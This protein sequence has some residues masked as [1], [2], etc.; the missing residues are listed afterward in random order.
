MIHVDYTWDLYPNKI[1]LDDELN[2]DRLGWQ[3]GDHFKLVNIDGK[4]QLVKIDPVV[5]FS[6]GYKVNG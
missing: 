1:I 6:Q 5:A 4:A 3:H 2:I